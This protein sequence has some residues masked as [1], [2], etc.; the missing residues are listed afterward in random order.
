MQRL[1]SL[2]AAVTRLTED[3]GSWQVPWGEINRFQRNDGAINQAFDDAKPSSPVPFASGSWGSLASFGASRRPGTKR[4]YGTSGNTFVAIVEFGRKLR[5]WAVREGGNSGNPASPHF[6]DQVERYASRQP[7]AGLL[8][9][10]ATS[11][12]MS[13]GGTSPASERY[14]ARTVALVPS[15]APAGSSARTWTKGPAATAEIAVSKPAR[16]W[17][18]TRASASARGPAHSSQVATSVAPFQLTRAATRP[19]RRVAT[20]AGARAGR[21]LQGNL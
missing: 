3:F 17:P 7:P 8:L 18:L 9:P 13:S 10:R 4:F 6:K 12:A 1:A 11:G 19:P 16:G 21:A 20:S 5:A 15:T 14:P 2:D